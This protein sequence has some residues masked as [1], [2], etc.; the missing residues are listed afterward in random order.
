MKKSWILP[1]AAVLGG[2]IGLFVRHRYLTTG[3]EPGTGLPVEGLPITT[4]SWA[5]VAIV[6]LAL[7]ALSYPK[8]AR[9]FEKQYTA[10]FQPTGFLSLTLRFAAMAL[11]LLAGFCNI[12]AY[13]TTYL[14]TG[15]RS[16]PIA[17]PI[18]G[19]LALL[20]AAGLYF[21]I[22]EMKKKKEVSSVWLTL[23]GFTCGLWVMASYQTWAQDPVPTRYLCSL[24]IVLLSLISCSL[25]AGFA[26][27]KG[28]VRRTLFVSA[29][30]A[31]LCL[32]A[33]GDGLP[34]Y[35]LTLVLAMLFY[36]LS[37]TASLAEHAAIPA[38]PDGGCNPQGGGCSGCSGCS[39]PDGSHPS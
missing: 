3:F 18:L 27:T 34:L 12:E 6:V 30:A 11:L 5:I 10:A 14:P 13:L 17:R 33:L 35:D 39:K 16:L 7:A 26:F 4:L 24:L 15:L 21:T 37:M 19:V 2:L 28:K 1:G 36:L 20:S 38:L 29:T 25:S 32:M 23:P 9:S 31:S 8:P 22:L